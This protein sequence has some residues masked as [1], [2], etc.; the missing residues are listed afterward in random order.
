M[1]KVTPRYVLGLNLRPINTKMVLVTI[2][3]KNTQIRMAVNVF[4]M[5]KYVRQIAIH[6]SSRPKPSQIAHEVNVIKDLFIKR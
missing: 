4:G 5:T 6:A 3:T 2:A 1:L